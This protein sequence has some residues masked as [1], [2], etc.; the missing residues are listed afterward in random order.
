MSRRHPGSRF[1]AQL[2][3]RRWAR[4]RL[5]VLD[6]DEWRCRICGAYG[7]E[8]DHIVPLHKGGAPYDPN[9]LQTQCRNCH[10]EKTRGENE[11]PDP[12]RDAWRK[13]VA[14]LL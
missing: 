7:N 5:Q 8:C 13:L 10:I 1:H 3:T 4:V 11:R 2:D 14:E 6:R 9:N 12:A